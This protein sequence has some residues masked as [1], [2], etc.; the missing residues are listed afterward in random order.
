MTSATIPAAPPLVPAVTGDFNAIE[1]CASSLLRAC[2]V[3]DDLDS[4][5]SAT[6]LHD[7]WNGAAARAYRERVR[8]PA[9]DAAAASA[10]VRAA[11]KAMHDFGDEFERLTYRRETLVE[12]RNSI[13][14]T[15]H[16]LHTQQRRLA[17]EPGSIAAQVHDLNRTIGEFET[18]CDSLQTSIDT[19]E[20]DLLAVLTHFMTV[21]AGRTAAAGGDLADSVMDRP[22]SPLKGGTPD[23]VAQW[24]R[25]LSDE[26]RFAVIAA[27]PDI[28]GAANGLPAAVRDQA[29]RLLLEQ[30]IAALDLAEARGEIPAELRAQRDN[31]RAAQEALANADGTSGVNSSRTRDPITQEPIPAFLLLY[32][33]AD[34]GN[35]G[36]IAI[37]IGDPDTADNLAVSVPGINTDGT[38]IP[39]YTQE[40][41]NLYESARL[42][43]PSTSSA[44]IAWIGYN[45]PS[46]S[47]IGRTPFEGAAREG[48][49]LLSDYVDGLKAARTHEPA[50]M[51]VFGHSYG[52]TTSSHAAAG[53][54][55]DVDNLVL[56]G[57]PG[58]SGGVSHASDL[59]V[60]Q[61]WVGNNSR[62][63]VGALG[64]KGAFGAGTFFGAGLGRDPAE[65]DFGAIR[66]EAEAPDRNSV[67]R[68]TS[69]H[70][71]YYER[72]SESIFN[73][74]Q[75]MVGDYDE[76]TLAEHKYD[77]WWGPPVDPEATRTP[78]PLDRDRQP[79][80]Q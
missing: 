53:D 17:Y 49:E 38:S 80:Q 9:K 2:V 19:N 57:S 69:D 31:I 22:G 73:M 10:A 24:W 79:D 70:V 8:E 66:F 47:N 14:H 37:A 58:A 41:Q 36:T 11:A 44:T 67:F 42:S 52:S 6:S 51:T 45:H 54:G 48:G 13:L 18:A 25:S 5:A 55:L 1:E 59:N 71:K 72:G 61:V 30:D 39:S 34:F 76:V 60:P 46:G 64:D 43:D 77:P 40:A 16:H 33:P 50:V 68:N 56:L 28:L 62:D 4:A 21:Q 27:Y 63:L 29:N 20:A 74:G 23:E 15:I 32:R 78:R 26:E 65:D 35:D 12:W 3:F 7:G 75:I